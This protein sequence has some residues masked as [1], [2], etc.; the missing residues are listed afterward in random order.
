MRGKEIGAA[1]FKEVIDYHETEY[2]T[3][4]AHVWHENIASVKCI[5][6]IGFTEVARLS[7]TKFTRKFRVDENG[8]LILVAR[9]KK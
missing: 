6:K 9:H 8:K 2:K 5:Q 7:T 1:L 3:I 4:Y